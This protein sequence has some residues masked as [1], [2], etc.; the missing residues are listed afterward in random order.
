MDSNRLFGVFAFVLA[1][2]SEFV[3]IS[4]LTSRIKI[5]RSSRR[6]G[7][8]LSLGSPKLKELANKLREA[9]FA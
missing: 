5:P 1:V 4:L 7:T 6:H 8:P 9:H 3:P 2:L